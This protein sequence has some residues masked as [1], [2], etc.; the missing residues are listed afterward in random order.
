[1]YEEQCQ[2]QCLQMQIHKEN[3]CQQSQ[4]MATMMWAM[5]GNQGVRMASNILPI[6]PPMGINLDH[7]AMQREKGIHEERW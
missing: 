4:F 7:E 3:M 2:E 5:M 6:I 1:M